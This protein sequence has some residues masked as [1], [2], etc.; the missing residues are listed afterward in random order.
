MDVVLTQ[1]LLGDDQEADLGEWLV[2]DGAT[3]EE[4]QAIASVE[5]SKLVN[6][7]V[8]PAAGVIT[9]KKEEGDLVELDE[10]IATI[11]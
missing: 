4:G 2:E 11:A 10:V 1:E 5:T 6:E 3:V 8:A 9:H 7:I